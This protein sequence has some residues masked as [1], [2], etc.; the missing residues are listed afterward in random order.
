MPKLA[1]SITGKFYTQDQK[2]AMWHDI[3]YRGKC[4]QCGGIDSMLQGPR[5]GLAENIKCKYC[6]MVFWITPFLGFGAYPIRD[7]TPTREQFQARAL[8]FYSDPL[9][10]EH[11]EEDKL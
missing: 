1:P 5:G 4:P 3:C 6:H 9:Y 11:N 10:L 2:D 8:L 7:D